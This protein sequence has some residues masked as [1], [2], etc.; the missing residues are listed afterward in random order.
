MS[1]KYLFTH[2]LKFLGFHIQK[3]PQNLPKIKCELVSHS[4]AIC[5]V[6]ESSVA[7]YNFVAF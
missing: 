2:I 5:C 3:T 1:C 6:F 4:F 7:I